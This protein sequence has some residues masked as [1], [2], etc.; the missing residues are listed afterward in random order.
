MESNRP[1]AV[2]IP[3][4]ESD[5]P[6]HTTLVEVSHSTVQP[7]P[8]KGMSSFEESTLSSQFEKVDD[9]FEQTLAEQINKTDDIPPT[10]TSTL[11]VPP[12]QTSMSVAYDVPSSVYSLPGSTSM[13]QKG[14]YVA[15]PDS[16]ISMP[17]N[18]MEMMP[19][20]QKVNHLPLHSKV[21]FHDTVHDEV[22][23]E[24]DEDSPYPEV[25]ASVS[26]IDDPNMPVNT[27]RM[28]VLGLLMAMIGGSI[29][30]FLALRY[31][32]PTLSPIVVQVVTYP[33]GNLAAKVL[34]THIYQLPPYLGGHRFTLNPGAF[35]IKE[36]AAISIMANIAILQAYVINF[37]MSVELPVF[38]GQDI[39]YGIQYV[40]AIANQCIGYGFAGLL[41]KFLVI[42]SSMIWP[43]ALVVSTILNTLHAQD[44]RDDRSIS[45]VR[46]F[47]YVLGACFLYHFIPNYFLKCI[48]QMC[49]VCWI[50]PTNRL[51]NIVNGVYGLGITSLTFDWGHISY[52][53]SPLIVPWWSECNVFAGFVLFAWG[54]MPALY[55][56][57]TWNSSYFAY[58]GSKAYDR[59]G[60]LYDISRVVDREAFEFDPES[61]Q[62]YS[63]IM[64]SLAFLISYFGGFGA[65]TSL[66]SHMLANHRHDIMCAFN[67]ER[68]RTDDVH[69]KLMRRYR[70][71][72]DW[73]YT[74]L[75]V[76]CFLAV[77]ST[78]DTSLVN[79]P[80]YA[81]I[82]AIGIAAA[83]MLPSGFV[84]ALSG[85]MIGTNVLTDVVGGYMLANHPQSFL[86]FKT[87][88]VQTLASALQ[89]TQGLKI[90]HYMKLP[91]RI[92]FTVQILSTILVLVVQL[93]LKKMLVS[94]VED[95]CTPGQ[96]SQLTC[97]RV[98]V[99]FSSSLL[100]S[101]VGPHKL[102]H[103][104][105]FRFSLYGL[106]AGAVLPLIPFYLRYRYPK[107][108][109]LR[110]VNVPIFF[111]GVQMLPISSSIN[112][113][114]WFAVAFV[115]QYLIRKYYFKWWSK[116][117]FVTSNALDAGTVMAELIIFFVLLLP[118]NGRWALNWWGNNVMEKT[119]DFQHQSLKPVPPG[120]IDVE[121]P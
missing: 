2:D 75:L 116:Y 28:W 49:W 113:T 6:N 7:P 110:Y 70:S 96:S 74:F 61:Y 90:G 59:Y 41:H 87:V 80:A 88:A 4:D 107:I 31:A 9:G 93:G 21:S 111:Y 53:T 114:A 1:A 103:S 38:Y 76:I 109:W 55:F 37:F 64:L 5:V 15:P 62:N 89:F 22:L 46:W 40:F 115:F 112:F 86:C 50:V 10:P 68:K 60:K 101:I 44:D 94:F 45:R 54:I 47:V 77:V 91:P 97:P 118:S 95:I 48:S 34:P 8:S 73:W 56:S 43:Q 14:Q 32:S 58:F 66:F 98:N 12:R 33:L 16:S 71:I 84:Y 92:T 57:N 51:A 82:V 29:N 26:N 27:V 36:H 17:E 99:F 79:M 83:F 117:N 13:P 72:P 42:P 100:W 19:L 104:G 3:E 78:V 24:D 30:T 108:I 18:E 105:A 63:P 20:S 102:Y 39:S 25:R 69:A 120:G 11:S 81:I 65:I 23:S 35:N 121:F 85:Q 106:L 119:A 67:E 52:I